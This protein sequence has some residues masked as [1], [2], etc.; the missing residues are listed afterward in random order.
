[1][2]CLVFFQTTASA[3]HGHC[4][5]RCRDWV[6]G[7]AFHPRGSLVGRPSDE[8]LVAWLFVLAVSPVRTSGF[9]RSPKALRS[10]PASPPASQ[11]GTFGTLPFAPAGSPGQWRKSDLQP[12]AAVAKVPPGSLQV[13]T[14]SGDST[15][16]IWDVAKE[17]CK[18]TLTDHTQPGTQR[19]GSMLW[20]RTIYGADVEVN[21][22]CL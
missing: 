1:M 9:R 4:A 16:K 13:A 20:N 7:I 17:K 15:V 18:H 6:S 22:I 12:G 11:L 21:S 14:S 5:A 2:G 19:L 8:S 3:A 10:P